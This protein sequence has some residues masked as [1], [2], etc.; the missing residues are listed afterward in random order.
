MTYAPYTNSSA[1]Y[2]GGAESPV[3]Y[4]GSATPSESYADPAPASAAKDDAEGT[5]DELKVTSDGYGEFH[6]NHFVAFSSVVTG[7]AEEAEQRAAARTQTLASQFTELFTLG[8]VCIATWG[9]PSYTFEGLPTVG[10]KFGGKRSDNLENLLGLFH[11]DWIA[12]QPD[13]ASHSFFARTLKR[14]W[15]EGLEGLLDMPSQRNAALA[16]SQI[17][18]LQVSQR[19]VLAGRRSWKV[20]FDRLLN[21]YFAETATVERNSSPILEWIDDNSTMPRETVVA[22]WTNLIENVIAHG[23]SQ[24]IEWLIPIGQHAESLLVYPPDVAEAYP[25]YTEEGNVLY[26]MGSSATM[27]QAVTQPWLAL[28]LERHPGLTQELTY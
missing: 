5:F 1:G 10:F 27:Q 14:R 7:S 13:A 21:R 28:V 22:V 9:P 19:H 12:L 16:V 11:T 3:G 20:G 6:T 24:G 4:A 26:R 2:A 17:I 25:G 18:A 8:S 15:K 23:P